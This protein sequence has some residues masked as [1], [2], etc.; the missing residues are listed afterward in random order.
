MGK[1][2]IKK[3]LN[4]I[5]LEK[6][7]L[8]LLENCEHCIPCSTEIEEDYVIFEYDEDN[9]KNA[10]DIQKN[11]LLD[12]LRF[13]YNCG[14]LE[15]LSKKYDFSMELKNLWIDINL[16]PYVLEKD[17]V[18]DSKFL[19][20][21]K[22]LIGTVLNPKYSF[23]DYYNGGIDLFKK[24]ENLNAIADI[25]EVEEIREILLHKFLNLDKKIQHQYKKVKKVKYKSFIILL[26]IFISLTCISITFL[27]IY[28]IDK[29]PQLTSTLKATNEY[30]KGN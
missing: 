10:S 1:L 25:Y 6:D 28:L 11:S 30:I 19:A 21:Y 7:K 14:C 9:L 16:M 18:K 12:R 13:C 17:K 3:L 8:F 27:G 24:D 26:P 20:K 5:R 22:A 4:E 29:K 2:I 23:Q 15:G